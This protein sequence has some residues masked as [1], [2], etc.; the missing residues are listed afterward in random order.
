MYVP[1]LGCA[2]DRAFAA[3]PSSTVHTKP[4]KRSV[5]VLSSRSECVRPGV[6]VVTTFPYKSVQG[7]GKARDTGC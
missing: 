7:E 6:Y 4:L 3:P 5:L 1:A 2:M